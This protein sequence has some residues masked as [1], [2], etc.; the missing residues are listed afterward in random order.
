MNLNLIIQSRI[1]FSSEIAEVVLQKNSTRKAFTN[2]DFSC[3]GF[4]ARKTVLRARL[5]TWEIVHVTI[6]NLMG[7]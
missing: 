2:Y 7:Q 6:N 3:T 5:C 4:R 1:S